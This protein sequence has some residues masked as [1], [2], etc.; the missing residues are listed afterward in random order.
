VVQ[1]LGTPQHVGALNAGTRNARVVYTWVDG[2]AQISVHLNPTNG[3]VTHKSE[4]N[5]K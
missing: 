4:Q 3:V 5:V 1:V 2:N